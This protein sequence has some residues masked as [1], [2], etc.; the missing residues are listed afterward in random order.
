MPSAS[1]LEVE[2]KWFITGIVAKE[3]N[4]MQGFHAPR[5][6]AIG[7]EAAGL[8]PWV[9]DAL[10]GCCVGPEDRMLWIGNPTAGYDHWFIKQ[11]SRG[12]A[13]GRRVIHVSS[14]E[15][16]N[17]VQRRNVVPGLFTREAEESAARRW[18]RESQI[19]AARVLGILP[20]GATTSLIGYHHLQAAR[21]RALALPA[22]WR[23]MDSEPVRLGCDV[24]RFG[25]DNTDVYAVQGPLAWHLETVSK[26]D[27]VAI[28][29]RLA[30]HVKATGARSVAIDG[31]GLGAGPI[32]ALRDLQRRGEAPEVEVFEVNF[33][34]APTRELESEVAD[35]RTELYWRLR[36]WLWTRAAVD[37]P[38]EVCEELLAPSYT[39]T[40]KPQV[41]RLEPKSDLKRRLQRSP[42][43]AD[44]LALAVSGHIGGSLGL[45][46]AG[47]QS[48]KRP[49][50][51]SF[52][53]NHPRHL[54]DDPDDA[55][56]DPLMGLR[57]GPRRW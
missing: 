17:Y 29:K 35:R 26:W 23:P 7:D 22:G 1:H 12:S 52:D 32:D 37:L 11:C 46:L 27:G 40:G 16:P 45:A 50:A 6:A 19:Y 4:A 47:A 43:K 2:P 51:N 57:G 30:Y 44:A 34:S 10:A 49:A 9:Q 36:D 14:L 15:T 48:Q 24:A 56:P 42:D 13:E 54:Q 53:M 31:G 33:G 38:E 3:Q 5:V 41:I 8:A 28:A 20:T 21:D 18:G 39:Y 55:A 25:E